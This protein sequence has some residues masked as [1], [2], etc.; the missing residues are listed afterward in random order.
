MLEAWLSSRNKT[1]TR[2]KH[3]TGN[4]VK[5]VPWFWPSGILPATGGNLQTQTHGVFAGLQTQEMCF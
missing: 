4:V 2:A 3:K 5:Y 1:N